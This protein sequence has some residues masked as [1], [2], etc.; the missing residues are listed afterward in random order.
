MRRS[1]ASSPPVG[2]W[3]WLAKAACDGLPVEQFIGPDG[4]LPTVRRQRERAAVQVCASCPVAAQ[5]LAH[6][7]TQPELFGVWGGTTEADRAAA[8]RGTV[9]A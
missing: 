3:E 1:R 9:A 4:E 2:G 6:A 7:L 8:R 5:C